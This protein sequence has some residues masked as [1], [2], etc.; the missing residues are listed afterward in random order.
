[1]CF[2][3]RGLKD[4]NDNK[5]K[6]CYE[7]CLRKVNVYNVKSIVCCCI[8]TDIPEFDPS[9]AAEMALTTTRLWLES[10][11]SNLSIKVTF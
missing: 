1:M 3:L 5:V 4:K 8:R 11:L 10:N 9:K 6:D 2:M 7:S